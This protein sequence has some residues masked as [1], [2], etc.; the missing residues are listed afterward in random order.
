M[1]IEGEESMEHEQA[2]ELLSDYLDGALSSEQRALFESHLSQCPACQADLDLLR[3]TLQLVRRMPK[4]EAPPQFARKVRRRAIKAGLLRGRGRF[5][6]ARFMVP[7]EATMVVLLATVGAMV[8]SQLL[9]LKPVEPTV[10]ENAPVNLWLDNT[11]QVNQV[12]QSVWNVEGEVR[13]FGRLAPPGSPLSAGGELEL[14]VPSSAWS[15]FVNSLQQAGWG[16]E[17]PKNVTAW[18]DGKIHVLILV[19]SPK[20]GPMAP[21][22]Q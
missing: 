13:V 10:V 22:R 2:Q 15:R 14:F 1:R 18:P 20:P 4:I 19:R 16:K 9:I 12:A 3:R 8:V 21:S 5:G 17:L 7:Y 11:P 6:L